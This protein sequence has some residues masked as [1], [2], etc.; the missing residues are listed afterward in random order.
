MSRLTGVW[1]ERNRETFT[2]FNGHSDNLK[3]NVYI[4]LSVPSMTLSYPKIKGNV[5]FN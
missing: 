4:V 2:G 5:Y 1:A 3:G